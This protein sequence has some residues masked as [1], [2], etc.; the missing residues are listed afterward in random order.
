MSRVPR[1]RSGGFDDRSSFLTAN[2][3]Q[4]TVGHFRSIVNTTVD[5]RATR[6]MSLPE[7]LALHLSQG[8][9]IEPAE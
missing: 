6:R 2:S 1:P 5:D 3:D 7:K 9:R 4:S 8:D